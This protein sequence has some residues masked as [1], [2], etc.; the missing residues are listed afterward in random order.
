MIG[1]VMSAYR[2]SDLM[3][4][5]DGQSKVRPLRGQVDCCQADWLGEDTAK[6]FLRSAV[7][8]PITTKSRRPPTHVRCLALRSD[9]E[10]GVNTHAPVLQHR[11]TLGGASQ[12]L[13]RV[14]IGIP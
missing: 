13:R 11:G 6:L 8:P 14:P 10:R 2:P 1:P 12:R 9:G 5:G 7:R 3:F 4:E